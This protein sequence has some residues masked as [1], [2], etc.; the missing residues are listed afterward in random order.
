MMF[1]GILVAMIAAAFIYAKGYEGGAGVQEGVR[2]GALIGLFMAGSGSGITRSS[3]SA[4][5]SRRRW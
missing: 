1:A 4:A 2:F 5:G 3:T